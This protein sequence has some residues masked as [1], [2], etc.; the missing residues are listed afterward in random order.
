MLSRINPSDLLLIKAKLLR[1]PAAFESA[2]QPKHLGREQPSIGCP[3]GKDSNEKGIAA[4]PQDE[5]LTD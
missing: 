3:L 1:D 5:L 4:D 2:V